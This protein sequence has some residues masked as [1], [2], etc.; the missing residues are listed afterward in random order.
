MKPPRGRDRW[1]R[2][3]LLLGVA[4]ALVVVFGSLLLMRA[5]AALEGRSDELLAAVGRA[6][7]LPISAEDLVVSWW[8]PGVTA[9]NVH[10]PDESPYG[11]GDLARADE[12]R[13][14]LALLPLLRG[15][16]VVTEVRLLSPVVFVVRGV[17]GGWN[18]SATPVRRP[19]PAEPGGESGLPSPR[20]VIDAIRTRDAR[21]VYRDR[22]IP[23]LGE[24][25]VRAGN[26][27]LRRQADGY[28]VDFNAQA[29]GGP[30]ENVEGWMTIPAAGPTSGDATLHIEARELSGE[31][32]PEVIALLRGDM[33]FGITLD[34][35]VAARADVTLP[36]AWPPSR[37]NGSLALDARE[38]ALRAAGGWVVKQ[39]GTALAIA[40]DLRAGPFGLAVDGA[41]LTS[42]DARLTARLADDAARDPDAGQ[43]P[44]VVALE[45]F[46][47][48]RLARWVPSL[49]R[50][51]P[52]G[53][54]E[55]E[56]RI[57][58][59][60]D[61]VATDL[62]MAGSSLD[63]HRGDR[64]FTV[65][66]ATL[67]LALAHGAEG[68][69][70][71]LRVDDVRTEDGTVGS[72]AADIGGPF[73]GPYSVR[74][75]GARLGRN[76]VELDGFAVD[77]LFDEERTDVRS[78][79]VVGIGGTLAARG[80]V[81]R[82]G[83]GSFAIAFDPEWNGLDFASLTR[84]LG[85]S[86]AGRGVFSGRASLET[87]ASDLD[88]GLA[89]LS[90]TFEV[91]LGNGALPGINVA[92]ATLASLDSIPRLEEAIDRRARERL[93]ALVARTSEIESLSI[94]GSIEA[95]HVAIAELH[96]RAA[97][98]AI[99]ATGRL[100]LDGAT[101]LSGE[102][103]LTRQASRSLVSGSGILEALAGGDEQIRIPI[104]VHGSYPNL[105]SRPSKEY[106]AQAAARALR[107]P[108]HERAAGFL[109]R[110]LG[111]GP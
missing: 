106:L 35:H 82:G 62:R 33:P 46:D 16:L 96:L 74:V 77:L 13:L 50:Y 8:P 37:A 59:G 6:A 30:E 23:G 31:R 91:S 65:G 90:G 71:A 76:G 41:S 64:T 12:A 5:R 52:R 94:R 55:M 109:R 34:G 51:T 101:D 47:A 107:L 42:E 53:E 29:L 22:A 89:N 44:L 95:G 19:P 15:E 72:A 43:Q 58:P 7:G 105:R 11:P 68:L 110:L 66:A 97:D 25:E 3:A 40:L 63:F 100:A 108:S 2:L 1:V 4:L 111:D 21:V 87:T 60:P 49:E 39:P 88:D 28:R 70:A 38:A 32:L 9:H 85:E 104:A 24:L 67:D 98:Y 102:L 61:G 80:R 54:L 103:L 27:L 86:D 17:D 48:T 93:P 78:L 57:T 83:D 10:I 20:V 14:Q 73:G 69:L 75:H 26:A 18:V 56:G 45:G 81:L 84:L 92:R 36:A 99:D 79:Q